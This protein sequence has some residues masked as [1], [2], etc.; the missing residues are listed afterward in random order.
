M[1]M[2]ATAKQKGKENQQGIALVIVL[3]FLS[4]LTIMAVSFAI[5]MRTERLTS[6]MYLDSARSRHL[7]DVALAR[8][9]SDIDYNMNN[10]PPALMAP[11]FDFLASGGNSSNVTLYT[12]AATNYLPSGWVGPIPQAQLQSIPNP[13][14]AAQPAIGQYAYLIANLTGY[15]DMNHV[16]LSNSRIKGRSPGEIRISPTLLD[17][18]IADTSWSTY[19]NSLRTRWRRIET[20][21]EFNA[22]TS[23]TILQ[24]ATGSK[25]FFPVSRSLPELNPNGQPKLDISGDKASLQTNATDIITALQSSGLTAA[26]A[27]GAFDALQDFV[28]TDVIPQNPN[29][30]SGEPVPMINE[31]VA[32]G[33]LER[34]LIDNINQIYRFTLRDFKIQVELWYPFPIDPNVAVTFRMD[35]ASVFSF[36]TVKGTPFPLYIPLFTAMNPTNAGATATITPNPV[37]I[38]QRGYYVVEFTYPNKTFDGTGN[39]FNAPGA[40]PVIDIVALDLAVLFGND[41][42]DVVSSPEPFQITLTPGAPRQAGISCLDPRINHLRGP[43]YW[44][45]QNNPSLGAMNVNTI[46]YT[47]GELI[48][49]DPVMYS[50]NAPLGFDKPGVGLGSVADL[51]YLSI[52]QPWR[53]IAL[54]DRPGV[55]TANP[56]LDYFTISNPTSSVH[57]LVNINTRRRDILASVFLDQ[58][59]DAAPELEPTLARIDANGARTIA[60][61]IIAQTSTRPFDGLAAMGKNMPTIYS[62]SFNNN[63]TSDDRIES[64]IRNSVN[65]MTTRQNVFGIMLDAKV[66][67]ENGN[68]TGNEKA[69]AVVW[70]DPA[71]I[72]GVNETIVR[73]FTWLTE[74]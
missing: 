25:H 65:L 41:R 69:L 62:A 37:T 22:L 55:F 15:L 51:G 6:R 33:N 48:G 36:T 53:T 13:V 26:E 56:V 66:L 24:S 28:D 46:A 34:Q 1:V 45:T 3:G 9:L 44:E 47:G 61:R 71:K 30:I 23:G 12:G 68:V 49:T 72:N 16:G 5:N 35:P 20:V 18:V 29:G 2:R 59:I 54:Y 32:S 43:P 73:Y 17:D 67:S 70:R 63:L 74:E 42:V 4:I 31:I 11:N 27:A 57:G 58:P 60:D 40:I 10:A 64:I 19:E 8:A 39:I 21:S 14:D 38:N 52:G 50:R 7:L